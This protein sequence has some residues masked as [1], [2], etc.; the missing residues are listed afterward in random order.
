MLAMAVIGVD[1]PLEIGIGYANVLIK[2][3]R[4]QHLLFWH[5]YRHPLFAHVATNLL[6]RHQK[7]LLAYPQEAPGTHN[8]VAGQAR[9]P[10]DVEVRHSPYLLACDIVD[11]EIADVLPR[12]L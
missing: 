9:F 6:N 5:H 4:I 8:Q 10:V 11:C 7:S 12:L 1:G 2:L 3:W